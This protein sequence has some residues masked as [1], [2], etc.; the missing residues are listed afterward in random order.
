MQN[1]RSRIS[2]Q[3]RKR[4]GL[5]A[6]LLA[7]LALAPVIALAQP[8]ND[9]WESAQELIGLWASVTN[10]N[11]G[12]T[13]QPG[14]PNHAGFPAANSIWYKWTAPRDGEVTVDTIGSTNQTPSFPLPP[15][16]D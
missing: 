1:L 14:E 4:S 3:A 16:M 6:G 12:A 10:D 13:P 7:G 2:A 8:A 11:S 9:N 5:A 15:E